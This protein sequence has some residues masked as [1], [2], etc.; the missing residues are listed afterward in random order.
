MYV[1]SPVVTSPAQWNQESDIWLYDEKETK[2]ETLKNGVQ[3]LLK[4]PRTEK[5]ITTGATTSPGGDS[6]EISDD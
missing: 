1:A 6:A 3:T 4:G 5:T 2:C